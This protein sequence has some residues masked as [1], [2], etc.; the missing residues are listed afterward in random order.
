[1][2]EAGG[3]VGLVELLRAGHESPAA[4][5]AAETLEVVLESCAANERATVA[6][7]LEQ[8][9]GLERGQV[10]ALSAFPGL[11]EKLQRAAE[12]VLM[13]AAERNDPTIFERAKREAEALELSSQ[14]L[15]A[16]T[17]RSCEVR[18]Q[19]EREVARKARR[20]SL[21]LGA[22]AT[23]NEFLCPITQ[24]VMIDPVVASDGHSYERV[25]IQAILDRG[26]NDGGS[27]LSPLTREELDHSLVPNINLRKR[28]REHDNEVECV[29]QQ[30]LR[31]V[32]GGG[33]NGMLISQSMGA[34]IASVGGVAGAI[35]SAGSPIAETGSMAVTAAL[36]SLGLHRYAQAFEEHGYDSWAEMVQM[37]SSQLGKLASIV[38]MASNH[39]DRLVSALQREAG[40]EPS[41]AVTL[42]GLG[43]SPLGAHT[44]LSL[45][46]TEQP[47]GSL[48]APPPT[49]PS[50]H[51]TE[52]CGEEV[53]GR[54]VD[55]GNVMLVGE[56]EGGVGGDLAGSEGSRA[57]ARAGSSSAEVGG[58]GEGGSAEGGSAEGGSSDGGSGSQPDEGSHEQSV[59]PREKGASSGRGPSSGRKRDAASVSSSE[60]G[61]AAS[62]GRKMRRVERR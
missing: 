7:I 56:A 32:Q 45:A 42:L 27:A 39:V 28:I 38:G 59:S 34:G 11:R 23:P 26:S 58:S 55:M 14:V 10:E 37:S 60:G 24:D 52:D 5:K 31:T 43:A 18:K 1:V 2:R 9:Q 33:A 41:G 53:E 47:E 40:V 17:A 49:P 57:E 13:T 19:A 46:A 44:E 30:V 16:A 15:A 35:D 50:A 54:M 8:Q 3:I 62:G 6:A 25:A 21:G 61:S 20:E 12:R 36:S 29:A 48:G 4:T 22:L 51:A